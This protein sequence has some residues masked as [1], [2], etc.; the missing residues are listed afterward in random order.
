LVVDTSNHLKS[1]LIPILIPI[2]VP[3]SYYFKAH[4]SCHNYYNYH[5]ILRRP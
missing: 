1:I 4:R 3:N 2:L 5:Q